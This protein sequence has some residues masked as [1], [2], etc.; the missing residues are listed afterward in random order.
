MIH[1]Q[2][3]QK[4]LTQISRLRSRRLFEDRKAVTIA[5]GAEIFGGI[6]IG[7]DTMVVASDGATTTGEKL[8]VGFSRSNQ[9]LFAISDA[10][11]DGRAARML[12][13]DILSSAIDASSGGRDFQQA[14]KRVMGR[15]HRSYGQTSS[16][17]VE[18]LLAVAIPSP[19]A[20]FGLFY[21]QPPSTVF[22]H[23]GPLAI[24]R[25]ARPVDP[26]LKAMLHGELH[27]KT[28]LLKLGYLMHVAKSEEGSACGEGTKAV[29][30]TTK[31]SCA[32]VTE[33]EME[34]TERLAVE[35]RSMV[36]NYRNALLSARTAEAFKREGNDLVNSFAE[37]LTK[38]ESLDFPSLRFL[39]TPVIF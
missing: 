21:C 9:A 19:R 33:H 20:T 18:F 14:I 25:G 28:A 1:A 4:P 26:L 37:F 22:K 38:A 30:I 3:R 8:A 31:R 12:A 27:A 24:G 36:D 23:L 32:F 29:I 7:A 11:E 15:W 16:P 10:A 5:I 34:Q 2:L 13:Q 39:D 17:A 6:V 35:C